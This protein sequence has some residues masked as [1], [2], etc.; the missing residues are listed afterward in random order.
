MRVL[1][2]GV[3]DGPLAPLPNGDLVAMD[4]EHVREFTDEHEDVH[5]V[6]ATTF[7][8]ASLAQGDSLSISFGGR[9]AITQGV[10]RVLVDWDHVLAI[11]PLA[12]A[13][14]RIE[15]TYGT[16]GKIRFEWDIMDS[17]G[18]TQ[19]WAGSALES[20]HVEVHG[21]SLPPP[22]V[23][24]GDGRTFPIPARHV[25][26]I[27]DLDVPESDPDWHG[28]GPGDALTDLRDVWVETVDG[29]TRL[30]M[31]FGE[32]SPGRVDDCVVQDA[33]VS[34]WFVMGFVGHLHQGV[35][36]H[37][38]SSPREDPQD[39][40]NVTVDRRNGLVRMDFDDAVPVAEHD[41]TVISSCGDDHIQAASDRFLLDVPSVP[42]AWVVAALGALALRRRP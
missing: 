21:G 12:P 31:R 25:V 22:D 42:L 38:G 28:D 3:G 19:N 37:S 18:T 27:A 30:T 23:A 1:E 41:W 34:L 17:T 8:F 36:F 35:G 20:F 11:G 16:P 2:D 9:V 13:D 39:M 5:R 32:I 7:V 4:L 15:T 10:S 14:P 40:A 6:L 29:H 33:S 26:R 24:N